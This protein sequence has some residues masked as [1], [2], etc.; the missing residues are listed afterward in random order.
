MNFLLSALSFNH[1][2]KVTYE[3]EHLTIYFRH[4][5]NVHLMSFTAVELKFYFPTALL[6][7]ACDKSMIVK[8]T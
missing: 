5:V 2:A 6:S 4:K 1:A 7:S 3:D 8:A